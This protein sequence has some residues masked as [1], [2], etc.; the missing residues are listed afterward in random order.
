MDEN[1]IFLM[2]LSLECIFQAKQWSML[3]ALI[4]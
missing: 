1:Q 3:H 4:A 2:H